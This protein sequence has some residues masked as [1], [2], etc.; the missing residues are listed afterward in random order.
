MPSP[1]LTLLAF[2]LS[3]SFSQVAAGELNAGKPAAMTS[4]TMEGIV[5]SRE[6]V[7][8]AEAINRE[9]LGSGLAP[10]VVVPVNLVGASNQE[11]DAKKLSSSD[12]RQKDAE[13]ETER[14][15]KR[16]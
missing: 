3:L 10:L 6:T 9:R 4:E 15:K 12:L 8:G 5:V 14:K 11:P 13:K 16:I 2:S 1:E 7:C